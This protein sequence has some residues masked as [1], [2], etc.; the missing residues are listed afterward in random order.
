MIV[1][2]FPEAVADTPVPTKSKT[3]RQSLVSANLK[4][5]PSCC[6]KIVKLSVGLK[7]K[8]VLM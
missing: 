1:E 7:N 2:I 8:T 4:P 5:L 3:V 6:K